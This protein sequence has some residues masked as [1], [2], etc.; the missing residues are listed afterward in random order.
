M[1]AVGLSYIIIYCLYYVEAHSFWAHFWSVFFF[2]NHKWVLNFVKAFSASIEMILCFLS[3]SLLI[4]ITLTDLHILKNPCKH[5]INP[6]WSW[7]MSFLIYCWILFARILLRSEAFSDFCPLSLS[8]VLLSESPQLP[9]W[10]SKIKSSLWGSFPVHGNS[11]S[12][13]TP[14]LPP[15]GH[16]LPSRSSPSFPFLCLHSLSY[17]IPGSLACPPGGLGSSEVA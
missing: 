8:F 5:G 7:Y 3:F 13:T 16:K 12:F 6:T 17:V 11:S 14:S 9:L 15:S 1:F 2:L 10:T 4:C